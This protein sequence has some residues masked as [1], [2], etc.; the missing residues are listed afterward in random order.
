M[1]QLVG[2]NEVR[3]L[4]NLFFASRRRMNIDIFPDRDPLQ[5]LDVKLFEMVISPA[6]TI[7]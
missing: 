6:S 2:L 1:Y 7:G 4:S 5:M 3:K